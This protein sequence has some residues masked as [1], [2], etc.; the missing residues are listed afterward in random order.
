MVNSINLYKE[1]LKSPFLIAGPCS[2][3]NEKITREVA[4]VLVNIAERHGWKLIFKSS[5]DK[6]NRT[7]IDS[8][9]GVGIEK[10]LS[11]LKKIKDDYKVPVITDVHECWQVKEVSSVVDIIQ[12]PAFLCRQTDLIVEASKTGRIINLKKGQFLSAHQM[13][14]SLEKVK[15]TGNEAILLTERGNSFGYGDLVVDIRNLVIMKSYGYSVVMDI[16]HSCQKPGINSK[17]TGGAIKYA[18]PIAKA[19]ASTGVQ[20]FFIETHPNPQKALSDADS[21]IPLKNMDS[22]SSELIDC[23]TYFQGSNK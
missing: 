17:T 1:L 19:A 4:E 3:E 21:M 15:S 16:T 10:G 20:G 11:I 14:H 5:F 6:A 13:I 7:S 23:V 22:F 18:L 9:R 12:I 2:I 8:F